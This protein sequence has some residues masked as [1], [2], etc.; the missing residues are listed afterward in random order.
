[1]IWVNGEMLPDEEARVSVADRGL[2]YGDG[3]FETMRVL[4]GQPVFLDEH[5]DR[6]LQGCQV[7]GIEWVDRGTFEYAVVVTIRAN[8]MDE[9]A[10]RLTVTR[11]VGGTRL[12]TAGADKPTVIVSCHEYRPPQLG[13]GPSLS[14]I[15]SKVRV[16]PDSP[17][18]G[19]KTLN[20]LDHIL[21]RREAKAVG[22]DEAL[23]LNTRGELT[24]A[25]AANVFVVTEDGFY[26]PP[27]SSGCL[28]GVTRGRLIHPPKL[29]AL[30]REEPLPAD[31]HGVEVSGR[32]RRWG[33]VESLL[34]TNSLLGV[35]VVARVGD[36][37]VATPEKRQATGEACHLIW[38]TMATLDATSAMLPETH[39]VSEVST[40]ADDVQAGR[41]GHRGRRTRR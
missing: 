17:T 36:A 27:L 25:T 29:P 24:C 7:L 30:G 3:L 20:R 4:L 14:A 19:L 8:Q 39:S 11:G 40:D 37:E 5:L 18:A 28:P 12:D 9:G 32:H 6:L 21:A 16:N 22:A 26:T 31:E 34:L 1:M 15:V 41:R 38:E 10:V 23:M 13:L 35:A 33:E 2:L